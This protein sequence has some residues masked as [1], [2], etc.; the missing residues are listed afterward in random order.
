MGIPA[1]RDCVDFLWDTSQHSLD[2][3]AEE[4]QICSFSRSR[5]MSQ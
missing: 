4:K 2:L 5:E 3:I 1:H